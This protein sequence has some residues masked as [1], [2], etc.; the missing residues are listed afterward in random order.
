MTY[1][2]TGV[3]IS[4]WPDQEGNKLKRPNSNFCKP[5]YKK[6]RPTRSPRHQWPLRRTKNGDLSIVFSV[7]SGLGLI[8]TPVYM[9]MVWGKMNQYTSYLQI[10]RKPW[11]DQEGNNAQHFNSTFKTDPTCLQGSLETGTKLGFWKLKWTEGIW[12]IRNQ[13]RHYVWHIWPAKPAQKY[14]PDE[15]FTYRTFVLNANF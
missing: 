6:V 3:L 4:H 9:H 1:I 15:F 14:C 10:C 5:L 13:H 11:L 12:N 8:S 7:G 2:Y